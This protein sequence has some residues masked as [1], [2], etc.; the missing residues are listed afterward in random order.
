[1]ET[2]VHGPDSGRQL[3]PRGH[4]RAP[5]LPPSWELYLSL[6]FSQPVHMAG[7]ETRVPSV[8][9]AHLAPPVTMLLGSVIV[10][11]ASL[12]LAVSRVGAHHDIYFVERDG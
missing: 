2:T 1:M 11:Q 6:P 7:L 3:A 12:G 9:T 10:H 8:A 4:L 5:S